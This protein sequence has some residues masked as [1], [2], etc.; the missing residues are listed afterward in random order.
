[1]LHNLTEALSVLN[2]AKADKLILESLFAQDARTIQARVLD[3]LE[4][5]DKN[6]KIKPDYRSTIAILQ[7]LFIVHYEDASLLLE[8]AEL[9]LRDKSSSWNLCQLYPLAISAILLA[10]V[11]CGTSSE[12][13]NPD[14]QMKLPRALGRMLRRFGDMSRMYANNKVDDWVVSQFLSGLNDYLD[15][16]KP[17]INWATRAEAILEPLKTLAVVGVGSEKFFAQLTH[18]V[19]SSLPFK[20]QHETLYEEL[21]ASKLR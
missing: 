2:D 15:S 16:K 4:T 1:M 21:V 10:A 20:R 7:V 12:V 11:S 9:G 3:L 13:Q 5:C 19:L 14:F 8:H 17:G 18:R 6:L